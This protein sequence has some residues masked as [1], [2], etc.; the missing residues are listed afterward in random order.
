[1]PNPRFR[2]SLRSLMLLIALC[3]C[4]YGLY[5]NWGPWRLTWQLHDEK[6]QPYGPSF[7]EDR[8]LYFGDAETGDTWTAWDIEKGV[9]LHS[10]TMG[11]LLAI[12]SMAGCLGYNTTGRS[13][14][15]RWHDPCF[16]ASSRFR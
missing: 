9:R 4:G 8:G 6:W 12:G 1:M 7:N 5:V 15:G 2:F 3:G 13:A 11:A 16:S 10:W 14:A